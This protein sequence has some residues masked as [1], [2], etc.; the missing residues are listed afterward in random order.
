MKILALILARGGSKRIPKKNVRLLG[1]KPLIS[2][3]IDAVK[4]LPEICE[5][6]VSTDDTEIKKIA[7]KFGAYVPWLRPY[8]LAT[9]I[10]SS[11]DAGGLRQSSPRLSPRISR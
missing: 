8:E 5:I 11:S 2:W 3:S 1:E 6:M 9:D 10:S 4:S 7:E